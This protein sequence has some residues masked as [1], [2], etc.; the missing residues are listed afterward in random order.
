MVLS[1]FALVTFAV[2]IIILVKNFGLERS[3][4]IHEV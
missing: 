3:K 1:M 2:L 4:K